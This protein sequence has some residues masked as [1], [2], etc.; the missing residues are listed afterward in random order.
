LERIDWWQGP[1]RRRV[2]HNPELDEFATLL[3]SILFP[4]KP[5]WTS[6]S[7]NFLPNV[8]EETSACWLVVGRDETPGSTVNSPE[9]PDTAEMKV[10]KVFISSS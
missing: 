7:Y 2:P 1:D 6:D 8:E 3:K 9:R 5:G 4:L 10:S